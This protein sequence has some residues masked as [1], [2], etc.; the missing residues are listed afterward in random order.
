M[1][2]Q[3]RFRQIYQ[4]KALMGMGCMDDGVGYGGYA[5]GGGKKRVCVKRHRVNKK[6]P[7]SRATGNWR[8]CEEWQPAKKAKKAPARRAPARR[9]PAKP[10][11]ALSEW[12]LFVSDYHAAHPHLTIGEA[13][14]LASPIYRREVGLM[15]PAPKKTRRAPRLTYQTA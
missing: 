4:Q 10:K 13:A 1:S 5:V 3:D 15:S 12:N 14:H 6:K 7:I 2:A 11:K 8:Y 9:A